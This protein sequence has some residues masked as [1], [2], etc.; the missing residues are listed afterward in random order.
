[1]VIVDVSIN[2]SGDTIPS[3]VKSVSKS[4]NRYNKKKRKEEKKKR[5]RKR[6][7]RADY[8]RP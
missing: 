6:K 1:M 2:S 7:R 5:S 8:V 3:I 4:R